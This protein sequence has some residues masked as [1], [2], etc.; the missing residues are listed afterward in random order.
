MSSRRELNQTNETAYSVGSEIRHDAEITLRY[1]ADAELALLPNAAIIQ[2][3]LSVK[4][5][6]STSSSFAQRF[7]QAVGQPHL[8]QIIQIGAGMQGV[9]FEQV[10]LVVTLPLQH[11]LLTIWIGWEVHCAEKGIPWERNPDN[12]PSARIFSASCCH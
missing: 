2:R 11:R 12:K 10:I 7:Q 9:V 1:L 3:S 8:Q 5:V 4:T 6:V